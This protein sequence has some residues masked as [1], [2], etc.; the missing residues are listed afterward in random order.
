MFFSLVL[1]IIDQQ[2]VLCVCVCV[3]GTFSSIVPRKLL[4]AGLNKVLPATYLFVGS[5]CGR[6]YM[7][8]CPVQLE[9]VAARHQAQKQVARKP[10]SRP[11]HEEHNGAPC[12][13]I[14]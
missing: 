1:T 13:I 14:K 7:S 4:P 2:R 12:N 9:L 3:L 10:K 5:G 8:W 11:A 6:E